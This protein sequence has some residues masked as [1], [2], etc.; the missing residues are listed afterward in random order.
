[1]V[2]NGRSGILILY[3]FVFFFFFGVV[4]ELSKVFMID[5]AKFVIVFLVGKTCVVW[6]C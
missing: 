5:G 6:C 4:Y 3:C 2:T 1:M